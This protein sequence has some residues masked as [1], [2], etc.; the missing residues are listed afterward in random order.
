MMPFECK[1]KAASKGKEF[2]QEI[3]VWDRQE[4]TVFCIDDK[5]KFLTLSLTSLS[6]HYLYSNHVQ[7]NMEVSQWHK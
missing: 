2:P 7:N 3:I 5:G 1:K 4:G 6:T